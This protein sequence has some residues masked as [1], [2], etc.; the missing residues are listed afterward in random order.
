M[1]TSIREHAPPIRSSLVLPR[2]SARAPAMTSTL[3]TRT[4]KN[5]TSVES[6][7]VS[8]K[9]RCHAVPTNSSGTRVQF[10]NEA[11]PWKRKQMLNRKRRVQHWPSRHRMKPCQR[12]TPAKAA[13]QGRQRERPGSSHC[14]KTGGNRA[15]HSTARRPELRQLLRRS[16]RH[17]CTCLLLAAHSLVTQRSISPCQSD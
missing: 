8:S 12:T 9:G 17:A 2:A 10:H 1:R 5:A 6:L 7:A 11:H 14:I 3:A 13:A 15:P 4:V 16:C